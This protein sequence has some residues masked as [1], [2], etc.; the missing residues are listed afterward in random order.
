MFLFFMPLVTSE[1]LG[2]VSGVT[3]IDFMLVYTL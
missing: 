3:F 2:S 1:V